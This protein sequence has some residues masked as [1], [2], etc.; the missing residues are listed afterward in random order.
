MTIPMPVEI[1][2]VTLAFPANALEFMPKWE[3]IPE[4]F[5]LGR[6]PWCDLQRTWFALGLTEHFS[7]QPAEIDGTRLDGNTIFRQLRAI[8]GTFA[9]KHEHKIAAVG[10]LASLWMEAVIYGP[11]DTKPEDLSVLGTASLEEW[12]EYIHD[13]G[14]AS[15][16]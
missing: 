13:E 12:L 16:D 7:F 9:C 10:Y 1:D 5:Q 15:A 11:P 14:E 3:D 6:S 4:E 2:D 8:Q